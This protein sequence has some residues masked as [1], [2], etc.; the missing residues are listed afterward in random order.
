MTTKTEAA[1]TDAIDQLTRARDSLSSML[2]DV[3]NGVSRQS[4]AGMESATAFRDEALAHLTRASRSTQRAVSRHPVE[5]AI[6][7]GVIGFSVGWVVKHMHARRNQDTI[8]STSKT[9]RPPRRP[10]TRP[11]G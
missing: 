9:P 4:A 3:L 10:R 2:R 6:L 11:E 5:T 1:I 7:V 8:P